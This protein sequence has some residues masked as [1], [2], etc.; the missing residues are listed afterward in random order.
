[1]NGPSDSGRVDLTQMIK[2]SDRKGGL[3]EKKRL[4]SYHGIQKNPR[5]DEPGDQTKPERE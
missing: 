2:T 1:M 3:N 5:K 4:R